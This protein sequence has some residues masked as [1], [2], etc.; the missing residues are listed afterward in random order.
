[1]GG[2]TLWGGD[3]GFVGGNVQ[4]SGRGASDFF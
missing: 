1:M 4:E 2:V 3:L